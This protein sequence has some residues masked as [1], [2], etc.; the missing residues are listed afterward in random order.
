M[1]KIFCILPF[2]AVL[3]IS[4]SALAEEE[5]T[6]L[7]TIVV[8][9]EDRSYLEVVRTK[10]DYYMPQR[11]QK[12]KPSFSYQV[13]L[14]PKEEVGAYF[15]SLDISFPVPSP[16]SE[17]MREVSPEPPPSPVIV[18]LP[19]QKE[20]IIVSSRE[21]RI[22]LARKKPPAK[23]EFIRP[24]LQI[25]RLER[26][27]YP[28]ISFPT[29]TA[30]YGKVAEVPTRREEI[31][32]SPPPSPTLTGMY[33]S[34]DKLLVMTTPEREKVKKAG[35]VEEVPK[36]KE[37]IG[38]PLYAEVPEKEMTQLSFPRIAMRV[39][40]L[41][42]VP[43]AQEV[44][45]RAYLASV[46]SGGEAYVE[47]APAGLEGERISPRQ[48]IL[49]K[50]V[51]GK[52]LP[53]EVTARAP[54]M[55]KVSYPQQ[56]EENEYPYLHFSVGISE[57]RSFKYNLDYGREQEKGRYLLN[58]ARVHSSHWVSYQQDF[59]SK[60]EDILQG[61]INWGELG[62]KETH[63]ILD[64]NQR[65]LEL[66]AGGKGT[67]TRFALDV[68]QIGTFDLWD[69]DVW[70]KSFTRREKDASGGDWDSLSYGTSLALHYEKLPFILK[71]EVEWQNL[72][73]KDDTQSTSSYQ[74][75]LGGKL[76][77]PLSISESLFLDLEAGVKGTGEGRAQAVGSFKLGWQGTEYWKVIIGGKQD[78]YLPEPSEVYLSR[79]YSWINPDLDPVEMTGLN[80]GVNYKND[81]WIEASLTA[82]FEDGEDLVWVYRDTPTPHLN[83]EIISLSRQG[84]R[85][86]GSWH[87]LP[88]VTLISS[89]M[90]KNIKNREG[91]EV[92]PHEPESIGEL[93]LR[94]ETEKWNLEV[95][96]QWQG[97]RYTT[98][99]KK[100]PLP[101]ASI[102][103]LR[104]VYKQDDWEAFF[105]VENNN[106]YYVSE[107]LQFPKDRFTL[108]I[109]LKLF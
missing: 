55:S 108:G 101:S 53:G 10:E 54:Q 2:V 36:A 6:E 89:Y 91:G 60:E 50:K 90:W 76:P 27:V 92:I 3:S 12:E 106:D 97:K 51:K 105:E 83:P 24:P 38:P 22:L 33:I 40:Q 7:P 18:Y 70:G 37:L 77:Q 17:K 31:G 25:P 66:P 42:P 79:D 26:N 82:F 49:L 73:E 11:G 85:V 57:N 45:A 56:I 43:S 4:L 71:G 1:K 62:E 48:E 15:P 19:P 46:P 88:A 75:L 30:E 39:P 9:G 81:P 21:A 34:E 58:L 107:D 14:P 94:T 61:S 86:K 67:D 93:A 99:E 5:L 63:I 64:G 96:Q 80:L 98:F 104:L 87:I 59:L 23:K 20:E 68:G 8:R 52:E 41:S 35:L 103:T 65:V 72:K 102:T 44:P 95:G 100:N 109:E 16:V 69:W 13:E 74:A 29:I 32:T 84:W 78:F 28:I 47:Y